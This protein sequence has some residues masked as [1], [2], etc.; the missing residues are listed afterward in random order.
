MKTKKKPTIFSPV[1]AGHVH[2]RPL[3]FRL[4]NRVTLFLLLLSGS[5]VLFYITG[6]Y[7]RFLDSDQHLLLDLCTA[8]G[9]TLAIFSFFSFI[10]SV[11][12]L[13]SLKNGSHLIF[14]LHSTVFIVV[15]IYALALTFAGRTI[16]FL[17]AGM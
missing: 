13:F 7:Q 8:T 6:N 10:E 17:A 4:T 3:L 11:Y 16:T 12:Y 15:F 1:R 5:L 2:R 9:I 14:I